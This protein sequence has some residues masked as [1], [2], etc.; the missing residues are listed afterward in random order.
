MPGPRHPRPQT[1]EEWLQRT[2]NAR[3]EA[4]FRAAQDRV[5]KIAVGDPAL[6]DEQRAE[7]V[8][9]LAPTGDTT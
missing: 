3:R 1:R 2:E 4:R 9:I 7:L 6:T 8:A 5:R